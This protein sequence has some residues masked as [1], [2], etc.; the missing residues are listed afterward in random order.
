M[1]IEE[2]NPVFAVYDNGTFERRSIN[3]P[4]PYDI[5]IIIKY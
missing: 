1:G 4:D 2:A 3:E 5:Y